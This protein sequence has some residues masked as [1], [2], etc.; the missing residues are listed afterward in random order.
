[1][2][3]RMFGTH[4]R[5]ANFSVPTEGECLQVIDRA[6]TLSTLNE[7]QAYLLTHLVRSFYRTD[8]EKT[9]ISDMTLM[10][11]HLMYV[12]AFG[13]EEVEEVDLDNPAIGV[14]AKVHYLE[15][16]PK[17]LPKNKPEAVTCSA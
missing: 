11:I 5:D 16:D 1:M 7:E 8:D 6:H 10:D 2:N 4:H 9:D 12:G 13:P 3:E 15:R 17:D 14:R